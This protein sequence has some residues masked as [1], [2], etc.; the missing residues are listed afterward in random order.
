MERRELVSGG[1]LAGL[2]AL[3]A[4]ASAASASAAQGSADN[5][6]LV[7]GAIGELRRSIE[8]QR[9]QPWRSIARV[10]A[11]QQMFL[12]A[13]Y[14]YPEFIEIGAAV[15]NAMHDWHVLFQQPLTMTRQ[16]DGRYQMAFM[17]T[18]LVLRPDQPLDYVGDAYDGPRTPLRP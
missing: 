12:R 14:K 1:V 2:A 9:D 18:T 15:W 13:T 4:P 5:D 6:E 8:Q 16:P 10:R 3:S 17:F 11:E 7:A